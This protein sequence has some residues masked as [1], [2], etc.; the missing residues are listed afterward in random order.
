MDKVQELLIKMLKRND[1]FKDM[2]DESLLKFSNLFKLDMASKGDAVIIENHN[3]ENVYILKTW[4]LL[5][6][7]ANW[8]NSVVLWQVNEWE[9]FGE[10]SFFYNKPAMASVVCDSDSASFWKI[11]KEDFKKFLDEN[12]KIKT[13]IMEVLSKREKNNKEKL[14]WKLDLRPSYDM[15]WIDDIEINL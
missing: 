11:S 14:W 3:P 13:M 6:K 1:F 5:A 4:T 7:K 15:E 9:T 10:M 2:C 12:P 8:L